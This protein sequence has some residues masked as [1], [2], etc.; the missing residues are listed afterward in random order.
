[1]GDPC[2]ADTFIGPLALAS[3]QQLLQEQ[4][5]AALAHGAAMLLPTD[6]T[7]AAGGRV[8]LAL[9]QGCST[10]LLHRDCQCT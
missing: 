1:M 6:A 7:R 9:L 5:G 10:V 3:T 8:I 2:E 4:V